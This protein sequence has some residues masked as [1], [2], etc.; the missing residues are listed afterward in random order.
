[1]SHFDVLAN[2]V[3]SIVV[4]ASQQDGSKATETG[5]GRSKSQAFV[6][7]PS[8]TLSLIC[9]HDFELKR[10]HKRSRSGPNALAVSVTDDEKRISFACCPVRLARSLVG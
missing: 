7:P 9:T 4:Q 8:I 2:S 6:L 1:M 5:Q 3:T 10:K